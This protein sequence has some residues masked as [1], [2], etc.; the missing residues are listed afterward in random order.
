MRID[1]ISSFPFE[2]PL[3]PHEITRFPG[4]DGQSVLVVETQLFNWT[5]KRYSEPLSWDIQW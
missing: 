3:S 5:I 2:V 4:K 1:E